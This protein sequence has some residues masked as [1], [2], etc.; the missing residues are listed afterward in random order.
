[1]SDLKSISFFDTLVYQAE[2]PE[3]LSN[4][5]FMD[6]CNEH[7]D[8]AIKNTKQKIKERQKKI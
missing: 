6:V 3:Y 4:K 2:I 8:N 1:M 5:D 7:T